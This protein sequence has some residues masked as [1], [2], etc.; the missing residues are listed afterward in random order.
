M[1]NHLITG[2]T[3]VNA[4]REQVADVRVRDGLVVEVK[5]NLKVAEDETVI[6]ATGKLVFPGGGDPHVHLHLPFMGAEGID[7]PATGSRGAVM[8]GTTWCIEMMWPD[9]PTTDP[10]AALDTYWLPRYRDSS[11]DYTFHAG[12]TGWGEQSEAWY[13]QMVD[14]GITSLKMFLAYEG[15]LGISDLAMFNGMTFAEKRG[16]VVTG[17]CEN[18]VLITQLQ[19]R[20][21][22]AGKIGP[23]SHYHSRPPAVEA[24]GT[25]HFCN[26]LAQT[27]AR[28]YVVHLSCE[29][30]LEQAMTAQRLGADVKVEVLIQHLLCT[31][32]DAERPD[33]EGAKF[34]MSPPLREAKNPPVL[35]NALAAGQIITVGSDQAG[36]SMAQKAMGADDFRAIPNGMATVADRFR[37]L[38]THGV[39]A[40]RLSR[41]RFVE[42]SS[43]AAAR[44][45]GLY[46]KKGLIAP[47]SDADIVVYDPN[48]NDVI[49]AETHGLAIEYS[50]FEGWPVK[51]RCDVVMVRGTVMAEK[52][53]YVG[54]PGHGK[55]MPRA[56]L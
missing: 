45:F 12:V 1:P 21:F 49:S 24:A 53:Q 28:G 50:N 39:A 18:A 8:G 15:A 30:A 31:K 37:L 5:P 43:T 48:V 9:K 3:V 6:D 22:D 52:G 56:A 42:V 44:Q 55:F 32:A 36:F 40:G 34:V 27:G 10:N 4:D 13:Q 41:T 47:G 46:P 20:L 29:E 38:Y 26:M 7:T 51:G 25:F 19:K 16:L 35:W 2:G 54:T 14:R 23:E 33:F 11:I 17:H